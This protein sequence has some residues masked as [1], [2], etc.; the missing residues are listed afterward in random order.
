MAESLTG[1]MFC[2]WATHLSGA[3]G[4]FKGGVV[5]YWPEV[6]ENLLRVDPKVM[7]KEGVVSEPVARAMAQGVKTLLKTDW[8]LATT[9]FAGPPNKK[10]AGEAGKTAFA[11]CSPFAYKTCIRYFKGEREETRYQA[12]LFALNFLLSD[13]TRRE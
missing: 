13:L 3:S 12:T 2:E 8:S 11:L 1:G 9:G 10:I 6:K 5:A 7:E 4:F